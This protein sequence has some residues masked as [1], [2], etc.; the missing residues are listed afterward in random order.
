MTLLQG[1]ILFWFGGAFAT[2]CS[3][4]VV[5]KA[6][7]NFKAWEMVV[8]SVV[9]PLSLAFAWRDHKKMSETLDQR[10]KEAVDA[11][12]EALPQHVHVNREALCHACGLSF[13]AVMTRISECP[14]CTP[15]SNEHEH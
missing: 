9:W 14:T 12:Y 11:C 8:G 4:T 3:V 6:G 7:G 5:S 15:L 2:A 10:F 1:F 13:D